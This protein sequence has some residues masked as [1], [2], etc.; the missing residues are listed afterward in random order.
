MLNL[1]SCT[2]ICFVV[3]RQEDPDASEIEAPLKDCDYCS[4]GRS[5]RLRERDQESQKDVPTL[6]PFELSAASKSSISTPSPSG[7]R[8]AISE[9][10]GQLSKNPESTRLISDGRSSIGTGTR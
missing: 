5:E 4:N 9:P 8:I 10:H 3:E 2:S 6:R 7:Y 1:A